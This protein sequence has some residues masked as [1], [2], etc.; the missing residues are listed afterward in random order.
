MVRPRRSGDAELLTRIVTA[1]EQRESLTAW[2][3]ADVSPAAG[4]GPAGL[5]KR[6]GSKAGLLRALTLQWIDQ[7]PSGPLP[8]DIDPEAELRSYVRREFG[9]ASPAGAI[10]ALAEILDE[11]Q[12]EE[13]TT[14][15]AEGW[16]R[17]SQWLA[18][19]LESIETRGLSD[20]NAC[21][22]MLLDA[23][24]GALFRSAVRL[25][26]SSPTFTLDTFLEIWK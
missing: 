16:S 25:E 18:R 19:L 7:I 23:L 8:A 21:G 3:L 15:L 14:L 17:Q 5:I 2:S 12:D 26:P 4:I 22:L 6:F 1:L 10:F 11:L 24:H 9:S 20:P 13:L